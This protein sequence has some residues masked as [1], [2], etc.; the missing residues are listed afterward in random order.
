M[1]DSLLPHN[2]TSQERDIEAVTGPALA[3]DV[4]LQA[5]WDPEICPEDLLPWLAWS[6]S[7]DNWDPKWAEEDKRAV[8]AGSV[9]VH[10]RKGTVGAV[11]QALTAAGYGT[12][13]IVEGKPSSLYDG[14]VRYDGAEIHEGPDHWA[15]YRI[16]LDRPIT[17]D[18][19]AQVRE[20]LTNVA[21]ARCH[22]KGLY[23]TQ[24]AH[25]YNAAVAYDGSYT[26][27]VIQ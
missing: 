14:T 20:I 22:L 26:H 13:R 10:R 27:G 24:A 15:E 18:Q 21:P 4:L 6:F 9:E 16:Y 7:V 3:P 8:I 19:A 12:A 1:P 25:R 5:L 2:A 17:I 23:F 11:R